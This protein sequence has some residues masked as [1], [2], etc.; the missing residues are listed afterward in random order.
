M[1]SGTN[2][3]CFS[4]HS[5]SRSS[6]DLLS[7]IVHSWSKHQWP[8][9]W[10]TCTFAPRIKKIWTIRK[11]SA[12]E[13]SFPTARISTSCSF[14]LMRFPSPRSSGNTRGW[15]YPVDWQR[16]VFHCFR[17]TPLKQ[18][19]RHLLRA[20]FLGRDITDTIRST[21][22]RADLLPRRNLNSR[23]LPYQ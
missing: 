4:P 8:D 22:Q 9:V 17:L 13:V 20:D 12:R 6:A 3:A 5:G 19:P 23:S 16:S 18:N 1:Q 2:A 7:S 14:L 21:A 10:C 11:N 15:A